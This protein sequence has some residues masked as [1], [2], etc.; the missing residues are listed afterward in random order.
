MRRGES[1]LGML[2]LRYCSYAI[3]KHTEQHPRAQDIVV[4]HTNNLSIVTRLR[5]AR[6]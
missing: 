5:L 3:S 1:G 6:H 2:S 4:W